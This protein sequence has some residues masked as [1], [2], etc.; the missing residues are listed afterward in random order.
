MAL[1]SELDRK[2]SVTLSLEADQSAHLRRQWIAHRLVGDNTSAQPLG[3]K[4]VRIRH[5]DAIELR[6]TRHFTPERPALSEPASGEDGFY[7][8]V[9]SSEERGAIGDLLLPAEAV[10]SSE[11]LHW[12]YDDLLPGHSLERPNGS[13]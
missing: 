11:I 3:G 6:G 1:E 8:I 12:K 2:Q 10:S 4:R 5:H 9:E 7:L 13:R